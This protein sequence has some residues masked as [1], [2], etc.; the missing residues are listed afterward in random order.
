MLQMLF[1]LNLLGPKRFLRYF[2]GLVLIM[3]FFLYCFV[4]EA[5]DS[6]NSR[7]HGTVVKIA[8]PVSKQTPYYARQGSAS[9]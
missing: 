4:H 6:P 7:Q 2:A 3:L 9:T 8:R 1:W 5:F